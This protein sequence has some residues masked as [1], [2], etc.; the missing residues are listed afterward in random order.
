MRAPR[1]PV[2]ELRDVAAAIDAAAARLAELVARERAF[3]SDVAHQLKTPLAALRLELEALA[4]SDR[5]GELSSTLTQVDRLEETVETLLAAARDTHRS[6]ARTSVKQVLAEIEREWR[7]LFAAQGRPLLVRSSADGEVITAPASVVREIVNVLLDNALRHGAGAVE[8]R[9]SR[10]GEMVRVEVRDQGPGVRGDAG[11]IFKRRA[12][13]GKGNGIGLA[14]ARSLAHAE[15]GE[16]A[17]TRPTP[18]VFT[19]ELP[20]HHSA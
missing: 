10:R 16:L 8:L 18:P 12:G 17:L 19:L 5:R 13:A 6:S 15:G 2:P 1:S 3:S 4:M 20:A 11:A 7:G 9:A 14:L